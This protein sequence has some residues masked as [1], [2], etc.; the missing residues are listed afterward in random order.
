VQPAVVV[1]LAD[2]AQL[3]SGGGAVTIAVTVACPVG[4]TALMSSVNVSQ[5]V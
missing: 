3:E 5:Q 2:T 4:V 1:E